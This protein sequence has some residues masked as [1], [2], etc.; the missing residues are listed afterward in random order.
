MGLKIELAVPKFPV[1]GM[2]VAKRELLELLF[3]GASDS[4][5]LAREPLASHGTV[6]HAFER[7]LG[8]IPE[9]LGMRFAVNRGFDDGYVWR[10]SQ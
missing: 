3:A 10:G 2:F 8:V 6:W 9:H 5:A 4:T 7:L 1:G